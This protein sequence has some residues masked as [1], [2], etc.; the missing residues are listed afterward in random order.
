MMQLASSADFTH[1][2][3]SCNLSVMIETMIVQNQCFS[4]NSAWKWEDSQGKH[5][6]VKTEYQYE[7]E[8]LMLWKNVVS[9]LLSKTSELL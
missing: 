9:L 4:S 7:D 6:I 3:E 2:V 8:I 5:E 1:L